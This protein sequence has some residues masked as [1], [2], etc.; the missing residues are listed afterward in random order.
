MDNVFVSYPNKWRQ[1][2]VPSTICPIR[3]IDEQTLRSFWLVTNNGFNFDEKEFST[4]TF[5]E[6]AN[7]HV[8]QLN[9]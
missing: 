7:I 4:V 8:G 2:N 6:Q 5:Y 1:T 9:T 3:I